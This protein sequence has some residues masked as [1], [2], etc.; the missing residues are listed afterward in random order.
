MLQ[1]LHGVRDR[2]LDGA[3]IQPGD[4]IID[5]GCGDGLI[6]FGALERTGEQG[7]VIFSDISSDLI[8]RCRRTAENMRMIGNCQFIVRP[9]TDLHGVADASVNVVTTRSVLIYVDDKAAAFAEFFR[10][11]EP[12]GRT[13]IGEPINQFTFPEPPGV[14]LGY[15]LSRLRELAGKLQAFYDRDELPKLSAMMEFNERD[16]L[17]IAERAGFRT[18]HMDLRIDIR[19]TL[20]QPWDR[21]LQTS[22]NPLSPTIEEAMRAAL[23]TGERERLTSHLKPLVESGAGTER[24]AFAFMTACKPAA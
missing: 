21:F 4:I 3:A 23:S 18:I 5:V 13:S 14:F 2:V 9:A 12:G 6:G 22:G 1:R 16:L 10:V 20:P 7:R 8:A 15:D 19:P 17:G 11:L 24:R